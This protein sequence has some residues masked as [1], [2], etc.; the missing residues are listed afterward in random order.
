MIPTVPEFTVSWMQWALQLAGLLF[1]MEV[2][3][4]TSAIEHLCTQLCSVLLKKI[5]LITYLF[6]VALC[7]PWC[8]QAFSSFS[9]P[10]QLLVAM[11]GLF[12]AVASLVAEHRLWHTDGLSSCGTQA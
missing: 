9:E 4:L 3:T 12:I 10:G 7:L 11:C 2:R 1:Q 6:L 8:L 5:F